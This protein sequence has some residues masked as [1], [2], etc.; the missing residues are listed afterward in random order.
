MGPFPSSHGFVYILLAVDYVSKWVE[1][2]ATRTNDSKVVL[3]FLRTNIFSRFGTPR[4][5]ISDG[6]THFCN[7]SF[8]ALLKKYNITHK[9]STPYHPQTSGQA[10][11][12]NREIKQILEK[13]VNSNRKDWSDR[14]DDAL[15]AYR[16]A[17]KTPIGMSPFRLVYGK[18]CH[19]PMELEHKA[20]WAIQ[21]LNFD[22]KAAGEHW[23]LQMNELDEL[24]NE[25]YESSR[26][27]KDKTK[28]FHD[29]MVL[30]KTFEVGQKVLLFDL[31][32]R[33]FPGKLRS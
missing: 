23:K 1:A 29:K 21:K 18:A 32:L 17:Y 31:R 15:W 22:M 25:A 12:S 9:V 4:A 2:L 14:L 8:E 27:Y 6:G 11:V 28:I 16:T 5:I 30:R 13:I 20:Y 33:L 3:S 24:R 26:I 10:E 19:L 7:R